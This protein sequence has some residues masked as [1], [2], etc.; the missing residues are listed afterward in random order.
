[1]FT[2]GPV[3]FCPAVDLNTRRTNCS[4]DCISDSN[5]TLPGA[6][7]CFDGCSHTCALAINDSNGEYFEVHYV[8][9]YM[10]NG[11]IYGDTALNLHT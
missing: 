2:G 10:Y 1:M 5:C 7:C 8:I 3:H 6:L 4:D 11:P 9:K